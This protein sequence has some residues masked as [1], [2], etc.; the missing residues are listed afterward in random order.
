[1]PAKSSGSV[2]RRGYAGM[3]ERWR[4]RA[5]ILHVPHVPEVRVLAALAREVR[6]DAPRPPQERM[7]VHELAGL[8]VL[9]VALGLVRNGRII[10]EWQL[11]QPSA[12]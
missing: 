3:I 6:P 11:K 8:R 1:M 7:V 10:C 5:R 2:S 9:A 4:D 12:M